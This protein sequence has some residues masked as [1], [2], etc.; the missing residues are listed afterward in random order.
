MKKEKLEHV[1]AA[2]QI[3]TGVNAKMIGDEASNKFDVCLA[4][5]SEMLGEIEVILKKRHADKVKEGL[6]IIIHHFQLLGLAKNER[7]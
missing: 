7:S 2:Y 3:G 5:T 1:F 4:E 6:P